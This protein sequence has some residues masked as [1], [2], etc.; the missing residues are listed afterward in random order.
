MNWEIFL[1]EMFVVLLLF[2]V[3]YVTSI[4]LKKRKIVGILLILVFFF[5]LL[6]QGLNYFPEPFDFDTPD[7]DDYYAVVDLTRPEGGTLYVRD[8]YLFSCELY[9]SDYLYHYPEIAKGILGLQYTSGSGRGESFWNWENSTLAGMPAKSISF[10]AIEPERFRFRTASFTSSPG[11]ALYEN[12]HV[13]VIFPEGYTLDSSSCEGTLCDDIEYSS[14]NGRDTITF[15]HKDPNT[16]KILYHL[17][18]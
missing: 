16:L 3:V 7:F 1:L 8:E 9:E 6:Y 14:E 12:W 2:A 15:I 18:K 13:K 10:Y 4:K 5:L 11:L 17:K